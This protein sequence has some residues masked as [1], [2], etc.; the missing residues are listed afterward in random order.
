METGSLT[1]KL[2]SLM[3]MVFTLGLEATVC[4]DLKWGLRVRSIGRSG[5]SDLM[6]KA[7]MVKHGNTPT[8][9]LLSGPTP[10]EATLRYSLMGLNTH[11]FV[12]DEYGNLISEDND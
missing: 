4:P 3:A 12:F 1:K 7:P 8:A 6:A 10:M 2:P 5:I 11:E 9:V